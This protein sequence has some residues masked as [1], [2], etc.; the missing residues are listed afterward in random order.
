[1]SNIIK[2]VLRKGKKRISKEVNNKVTSRKMN[3]ALRFTEW[4]NFNSEDL[5]FANQLIM[6]KQSISE[7][8]T[9][10]W[11]VPNFLHPYG[12]VFTIFRI[13]NYLQEKGFDNRIIIY[14][15]PDFE[16]GSRSAIIHKYFP[17]IKLDQILA[18][19]NGIKD[20]P[21]SDFCV[22]TF[23]TSCYQLMKIRNTKRKL[24]LIQDFEPG[25]YTADT[26]FAIVENTYRMPYN[27]IFNTSGLNKYV[28]TNYPN[29]NI[30]SMY[31]TPAV[32]E[33][34]VFTPKKLDGKIKVLFYGRPFTPRNAF[35]LTLSF[36][37]EIKTKYGD[38]VEVIS[39]GEKYNLKDFG[40]G[41][42]EKYF[43]NVGIIPYDKL[44][45]FYSQFHFTISF[46]LTKHPS[47]LPFEAMANGS[48]VIANYN[49][50]N[51]WL[52]ENK[53]NSI[54]VPP[55]VDMLV[56]AFDEV[57]KSPELYNKILHNAN[58]TVKKVSW[59]SEMERVYNFFTELI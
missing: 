1:M 36:I 18:L 21:D 51:T 22:S 58:S 10:N 9:V 11:L 28:D 2:D 57:V 12:G 53:V 46:M 56:E 35:E 29:S 25:F 42:Y 48:V 50:A 52:L 40:L 43:T 54:F 6:N 31:F 45:E 59:E 3:E 27:R 26:V 15:N 16:I 7:N 5:E 33:S 30:K 17:N 19:K 38:R 32:D 34:Y 23:W 41:D 44:P 8:K 13:A 47:Y 55:S 39:A 24:Y 14:D 20:V 37:K 4:F 49:E